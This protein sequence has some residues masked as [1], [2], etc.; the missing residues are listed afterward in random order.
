MNGIPVPSTCA[1]GADWGAAAV[2][3]VG[4]VAGAGA[5]IAT[6]AGSTPV[7]SANVLTAAAWTRSQ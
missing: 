5:A 3:G 1:A 7:A 4:L 2:G 6:R